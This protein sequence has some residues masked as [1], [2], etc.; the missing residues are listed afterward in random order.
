MADCLSKINVCMRDVLE[1]VVYLCACALILILWAMQFHG[2]F[3]NDR[4]IK[5]ET[6]D[7]CYCRIWHDIITHINVSSFHFPRSLFFRF[8]QHTR[9]QT[10]T[11]MAYIGR[12]RMKMQQR[13]T[14]HLNLRVIQNALQSSKILI[15]THF[16]ALFF[17]FFFSLSVDTNSGRI[18]A[19]LHQNWKS[20]SFYGTIWQMDGRRVKHRKQFHL[21]SRVCVCMKLNVTKKKMKQL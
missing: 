1:Y 19:F 21:E 2:E 7:F 17:F 12:I 14:I 18:D 3:Q 11:C 20:N 16:Y 15:A 8:K 4:W 10:H 9:I 13:I 6:Y 5:I